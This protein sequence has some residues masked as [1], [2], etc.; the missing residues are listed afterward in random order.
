MEKERV[1]GEIPPRVSLSSV[2]SKQRRLEGLVNPMFYLLT[3]EKKQ[4]ISC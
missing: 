3:D 2:R 1:G 4:L